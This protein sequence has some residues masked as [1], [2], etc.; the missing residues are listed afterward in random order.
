MKLTDGQKKPE[1]KMLFENE[2]SLS[3][4][5]EMLLMV[6]RGCRP[7]VLALPMMKRKKESIVTVRTDDC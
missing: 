1:K 4:Y 2:N 7:N 6:I 3:R 5:L